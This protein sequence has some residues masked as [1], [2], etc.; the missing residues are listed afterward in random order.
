MPRVARI[1]V[2]GVPHHVTQRG[3]NRQEVFFVDDDR[4]VCLDLLERQAQTFL[5]KAERMLGRRLRPLPVGRQRK[6]EDDEE[7]GWLSLVSP[8]FPV[9]GFPDAG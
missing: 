9:P 5:S 4:M 3:N 2:P 7:S 6:T 1:I 8:W